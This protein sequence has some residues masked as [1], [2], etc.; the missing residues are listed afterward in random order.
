MSKSDDLGIDLEQGLLD[1]R[2]KA[3]ASKP[4]DISNPSGLC[5]Y[6]DDDTG[7]YVRWCDA[8]CRDDWSMENE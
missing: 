2:I 8:D 5:W 3:A 4:L 1:M 7:S 6:C